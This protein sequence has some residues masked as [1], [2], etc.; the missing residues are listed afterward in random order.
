MRKSK[1]SGRG[2]FANKLIRKGELII[3]FEKG[4]GKFINS[5]EADKL[6]NAGNDH[7]LQIGD[8]LFFAAI[9]PEQYENEDHINHSCDPN[10]GIDGNMKFVA[11]RDIQA[12]E[13]LTFDYAMSESSD[14]K[15]GCHCGSINCRKIIT[16]SDWKRKDLQEKYH[17]FF[18]NYL[19]SKFLVN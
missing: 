6:Y 15:M 17:G 7:M 12:D 9:T 2:L 3:S 16:G 1:I 11:M 14:Y 19:Q 4:K 10:L 13:E 8:D 18:S 5:T